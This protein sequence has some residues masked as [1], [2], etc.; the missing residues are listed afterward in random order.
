MAMKASVNVL[1]C[2]IWKLQDLSFKFK[3]KKTLQA[4]EPKQSTFLKTCLVFPLCLQLWSVW[5]DPGDLQS[6]RKPHELPLHHAHLTGNEEKGALRRVDICRWGSQWFLL[7]WSFVSFS[8]HFDTRLAVTR[9]CTLKLICSCATQ[10]GKEAGGSGPGGCSH[11]ALVV[12]GGGGREW[13]VA[14]AFSMFLHFCFSFSFVRGLFG[15]KSYCMLW[16]IKTGML[17]LDLTSHWSKMALKHWIFPLFAL[18]I[19]WI[20]SL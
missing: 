12:G 8:L 9:I 19:R 3:L 4:N 16:A 10:I 7:S 20:N 2:I 1:F 15:L 18:T 13:Q 5:S 17:I 6:R 11:F 14:V